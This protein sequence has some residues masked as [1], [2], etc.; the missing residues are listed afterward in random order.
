MKRIGFAI[1]LAAIALAAQN[2][3]AGVI[4]IQISGLNLKYDAANDTVVDINA[5]GTA[6]GGNHDDAEADLLNATVFLVD[7]IAQQ[8]PLMNGEQYGDF[9]EDLAATITDT[10]IGNPVEFGTT[11][12]GGG[13]YGFEW[14]KEDGGAL[15]YFLDL[16]FDE[17]TYV[18]TPTSFQLTGV[19]SS[20]AGQQLPYNLAFDTSQPI[21]VTY[22]S[23]NF[24]KM[25]HVNGGSATVD[26]INASGQIIVAGQMS[27][28]PEPAGISLLAGLGA[29]AAGVRWRWG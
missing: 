15:E 9:Y 10:G 25:T 17:L 5:G 14:F 13:K 3:S 7:G 29:L 8:P 12:G 26:M 11:E 23:T 19:V 20:L 2:A 22:Q 24:M 18:L 4:E 21:T 27:A 6:A 16:E 1:A 28:I